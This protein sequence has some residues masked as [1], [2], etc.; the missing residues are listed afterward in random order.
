[1]LNGRIHPVGQV[2]GFSIELGASGSF[3]PN[4]IRLPMKAYFFNLSDDNAPSPY[5]GYAD[6]KQLPSNKGYHI[7]KKGSIQVSSLLLFV[8]CY[9]SFS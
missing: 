1:M 9:Q 2:E 5:L 8:S 6:L 3:Y 4:H 7:P